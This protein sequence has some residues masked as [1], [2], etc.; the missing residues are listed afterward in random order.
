MCQG[1]V[2]ERLTDNGLSESVVREAEKALLL[3]EARPDLAL[4]CSPAR[5]VQG[6]KRSGDQ[7]PNRREKV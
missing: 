7:R 5:L 3:V 4:P 1:R 2:R 6:S